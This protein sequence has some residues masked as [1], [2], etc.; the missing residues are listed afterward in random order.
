VR[1]RAVAVI[2]TIW[3]VAGSGAWL[4]AAAPAPAAPATTA[5]VIASIDRYVT[6]QMGALHIPGLALTLVVH[7]R[8]AYERGYGVADPS[9]RPVTP[10]TPFIIGSTSKQFTGIAV[11]QLIR[12]RRL[13]LD[14]P[15]TRYLPWFGSGSDPH[16][17][18]TIRELLSHTSGIEGWQGA[19][20]VLEDGGP[21]DTLEANAHRLAG[22]TL[23][24]AP[25]SAFAYTNSNYD[26]LGYLVEVVTGQ[27]YPDYMRE[28]VFAPLGLR[29]TYTDK[30]DAEAH[31]LAAG[32]YP[33]FGLLTLPVPMPYPRS[34]LPSGFLI[35]SAHD[36]AT[37]VLAQ[38]G[39]VPGGQTEIDRPLLA[40]TRVPLATIDR[41]TR[42][43]AGWF[44]RRFWEDA[45]TG[46]DADDPALPLLYEHAGNAH[47]FRSYIGFV[48]DLGFGL[49]VTM[50]A[51]DVLGPAAAPWDNL[52]NG[53]IRLALG[54]E[55]SPPAVYGDPL[56]R[57]ARL[58]YV[59]GAMAVVAASIWA[60]RA[61]RRRRL[62]IAIAAV[63]DLFAVGLA[64]VYA[65]TK[66]GEPLVAVVRFFPD[67]GLMTVAVVAVAIAFFALLL[68]QALMA[69]RGPAAPSASSAETTE[70]G[71]EASS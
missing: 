70:H 20:N 65:P 61:R 14:A 43:A 47:T 63:V 54:R 60:L 46:Q 30:A 21:S 37:L 48:P 39:S 22:E 13:E 58:A 6:E 53:I 29:D 27:S 50:N 2:G 57:N 3:L 38:L 62:A 42:Y 49:A 67:L 19:A 52:G 45:T 4:T 1:T 7:G 24:G 40:A 69:R 8:V 68:R 71:S 26:L 66:M 41:S 17:R 12:A 56:D 55:P 31:G 25:G 28:H 15:V 9:G 23:A 11:E 18:V 51:T 10:D 32:F 59:L 33:W 44:V 35:S 16:A 34:S 5:T 36:L 64:L